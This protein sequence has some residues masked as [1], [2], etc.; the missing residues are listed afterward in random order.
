[1]PLFVWTLY[2]IT[3]KILYSKALTWTHVIITVL[4]L[5]FVI[6][7]LF[8]A[9]DLYHPTPPRYYDYNNWN[10]FKAYDMYNNTIANIIAILLIGQIIFIV[11][12]IA[13]LLKRST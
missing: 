8:F 1:M 2:L 9:N 6:L 10:S 7:I 4:T 11:N 13:G 3:D 12:L 5:A